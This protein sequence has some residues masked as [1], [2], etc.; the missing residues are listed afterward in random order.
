MSYEI[1]LESKIEKIT[2]DIQLDRLKLSVTNNT[3]LLE[4]HRL[5]YG[6]ILADIEHRKLNLKKDLDNK[7]RNISF[8]FIRNVK[9]IFRT[10]IETIIDTFNY[11]SNFN[12]IINSNYENNELVDKLKHDLILYT[13][14]GNDESLC[15]TFNNDNIDHWMY[16]S[17]G[18]LYTQDGCLN[19]ILE[20]INNFDELL[21]ETKKHTN[22]DLNGFIQKM[23]VDVKKTD[24]CLEINKIY[25]KVFLM[26]YMYF[27]MK[28]N[29]KLL[30]KDI[31][32]DSFN[33]VKKDNLSH[34][35]NSKTELEKLEKKKER[36][37]KFIENIEADIESSKNKIDFLNEQSRNLITRIKNYEKI[38]E[39]DK[40][41]K[42][43]DNHRQ[44]NNYYILP[45]LF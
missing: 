10:H 21:L 41:Q 33:E 4:K 17:M 15:S 45:N 19:H 5:I 34:I 39:L 1:L 11:D 6:T 44:K 7:D 31:L 22:M 16:L 8:K 13:M 35:E 9:T 27:D 37:I 24:L 42:E 2:N 30:S 29:F 43:L 18:E 40:L 3:V 38:N 14:F 25:T 23:L 26:I 32:L 28:Y 12:L 20:N 36:K